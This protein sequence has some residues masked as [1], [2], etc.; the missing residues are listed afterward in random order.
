M[1]CCFF[2]LFF[3]SAK[4]N[5]FIAQKQRAD[6]TTPHQSNSTRKKSIRRNVKHT[7]KKRSWKIYL[8]IYT[9]PDLYGGMT[10][11]RWNYNNK[12]EKDEQKIIMKWTH[13]T[14]IKA[15]AMITFKKNK[16]F[17]MLLSVQA[18]QQQQQ[19]RQINYF[20]FFQSRG[21]VNK[22]IISRDLFLRNIHSTQE[23]SWHKNIYIFL[24]LFFH[25]NFDPKTFR[26]YL[27]QTRRFWIYLENV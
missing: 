15:L 20:C 25:L 12:N 3:F 23:G 26:K 8:Q 14:K 10:T 17:H 13:S 16:S 19:N 27:C 1:F 9:L 4:V 7:K 18:T 6:K 24:F 21:R 2:S 5:I 11:G 22:L